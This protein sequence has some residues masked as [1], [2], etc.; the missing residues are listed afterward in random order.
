MELTGVVGKGGLLRVV[1]FEFRDRHRQ[2]QDKDK[3]EAEKT[4]FF[5]ASEAV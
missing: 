4:C 2:K 3:E 5:A 1:S